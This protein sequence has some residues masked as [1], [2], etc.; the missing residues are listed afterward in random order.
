MKSVLLVALL[1]VSTQL[2]AQDAIPAGTVLPVR[3]ESSLSKKSAAGR[4]IKAIIMQDVPLANGSKLPAGSTV[5]GEVVNVASNSSNPGTQI[6]LKFDRVVS[7]NRTTPL[8]T[9][10]RALASISEVDDAQVPDM[11]PDRG[12]PPSAY[13]TVQVGGDEVVYRGGGHVMDAS[14]VV[15]EPVPDGVVGRVRPNTLRGCRGEIDKQEP[16]QQALWVFASD[17]CGVYGYAN[18]KIVNSGRDNPL[19]AIIIAAERGDL[20]IAGG[21]GMLLRVISNQPAVQVSGRS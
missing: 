10:L 18:L 12:T 8:T 14:E 9:D 13:T 20:K 1:A 11:G 16:A 2:Y 3:L 15:G 4:L 19:G 7:S 21:S 6:T 5:L 17:A